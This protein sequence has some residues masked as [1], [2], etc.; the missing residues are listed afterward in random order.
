MKLLQFVN[1]P[2]YV[3]FLYKMKHVLQYKESC[4]ISKISNFVCYLNWCICSIC[5]LHFKKEQKNLRDFLSKLYPFNFTI[6]KSWG[7]Q[8]NA[9][10]SS[11]KTATV[12]NSFSTYS[13]H[14]SITCD[15][16]YIFFNRQKQ[17]QKVCHWYGLEIYHLWSVRKVLKSHLE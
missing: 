14:S 6:S 4:V 11:M 3:G 12:K 16:S 5:F 10:D 17:N 8:S 9:L 15:L 1:N 2:V 13:F 7:M